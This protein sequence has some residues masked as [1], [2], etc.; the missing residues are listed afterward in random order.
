MS[1]QLHHFTAAQLEAAHRSVVNA[2]S[3]AHTSNE[4]EYA[5]LR[6]RALHKQQLK[7][8]RAVSTRK[9]ARPNDT[10]PSQPPPPPPPPRGQLQP[11][12]KEWPALLRVLEEVAPVPPLESMSTAA[13][14]SVSQHSA[15]PPAAAMQ[16]AGPQ[17]MLTSLHCCVVRTQVE[18]AV[19]RYERRCMLRRVHQYRAVL[20]W[21]GLEPSP[22]STRLTVTPASDDDQPTRERATQARKK[23]AQS[24]GDWQYC[25]IC[26]EQPRRRKEVLIRRCG[27]AMCRA[28]LSGLRRVRDLHCPTCRVS[29]SVPSEVQLLVACRA[30]DLL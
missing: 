20:D 13:L 16:L 14:S 26:A 17:A 6:Q 3:R 1:V 4:S 28:C 8:G 24:V 23:R 12:C 15:Q 29:F 27:H 22:I 18:S 30:S 10:A 9:R 11:G 2:K 19:L 21:F 7:E 25:E 5:R